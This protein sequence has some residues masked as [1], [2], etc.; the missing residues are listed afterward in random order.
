MSSTTEV[1]AKMAA[2]LA[3]AAVDLR[4]DLWCLRMPTGSPFGWNGV[5][6]DFR[7]LLAEME[8]GL[9]NLDVKVVRD[10]ANKAR[11]IGAMLSPDAQARIQIGPNLNSRP[12]RSSSAIVAADWPN[13]LP[14]IDSA[15]TSR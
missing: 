12:V 11:N 1:V 4:R 15:G 5:A 14:A 2:V 8:T 7:E 3:G 6:E 9:Q 13:H 10:A